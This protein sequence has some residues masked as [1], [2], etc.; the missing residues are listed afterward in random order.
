MLMI[1]HPLARLLP[2]FPLDP[3]SPV[4]LNMVLGTQTLFV[5][6]Q[7]TG[8]KVWPIRKVR[9]V[10]RGSR[11]AASALSLSFSLS[12]WLPFPVLTTTPLAAPPQL[13]QT[14]KENFRSRMKLIQR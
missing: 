4:S 5:V 8:G 1:I 7:R 3:L 13:T 6:F 10:P 9:F 11:P 14:R 2:L 12:S